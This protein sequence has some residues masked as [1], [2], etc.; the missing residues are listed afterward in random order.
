[1]AKQRRWVFL[2]FWEDRLLNNKIGDR[3]LTRDGWLSF[4]TGCNAREGYG[5]LS[6]KSAYSCNGFNMGCFLPLPP[7][8]AAAKAG[9]NNIGHVQNP[10]PSQFPPIGEYYSKTILNTVQYIYD[11]QR[12]CADVSSP[13]E[14]NDELTQCRRSTLATITIGHEKRSPQTSLPLKI[15]RKNIWIEEKSRCLICI[16]FF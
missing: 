13:Y 3:Q 12:H 7:P 5:N 10:F 14:Q 16:I 2:L 9:R 11:Y 15:T 8:L 4:G 6:C 1:M